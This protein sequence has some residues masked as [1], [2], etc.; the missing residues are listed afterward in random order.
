MKVSSRIFIVGAGFAGKAIARELKEKEPG[1]IIAA[2]LDDDREKIGTEVD[3][4]PVMGPISGCIRLLKDCYNDEA[5]IACPSATRQ[6]IKDI[7]ALLSQTDIGRIRILP[8]VSSIVTGDVHLVQARD[9]DPEDLLGRTPVSINLSETLRNLRGKRVLITGAG[10]SIGTELSRQLLHAGA[11]RLYIL[12]HGENSIYHLE[13]EL[14]RLQAGGVG[15]EAVIVPVIGELQDRDF[16]FFILKRLKADYIFHTAAHKHV[17]MME[18]NPVA[19]ISN[20]VFGTLNLRD[21]ARAAG[22]KRLILISTDKAVQPSCVYGASK[23]LAEMIVLEKEEGEI[24]TDFMVVRFGNV[25]GARGTIIPLFK[26]QILTGGPVTVTHEEMTRFY[27]TIPEAVS[28]ILKTGGDGL[29]GG[30]YMLDMGTPLRIVDMA[31]QMIRFYGYSEEQIGIKYIGLREGEK[32]DEQLWDRKSEELIPSGEERIFK[33]SQRL[34]HYPPSREILNRLRPICF[35]DRDQSHLYRNRR[36]LRQIL[37]EYFPTVRNP[38]D[39]PE[40]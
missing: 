32:L 16:L 20:N 8:T 29:D 7:Y 25:L 14:K 38:D 11:E 37:T 26:Q 27:M 19:A 34:D 13:K 33:V 10:G 22:T 9:I 28:L 18:K 2:F 24:S 1:R 3:G 12:G 36:Y 31:R 17:P 5:I 40:Y 15:R 35:P 30:L 6:Q 4:I 21:A 39:E 23:K